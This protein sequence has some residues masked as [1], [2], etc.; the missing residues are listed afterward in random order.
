MG[1]FVLDASCIYNWVTI[2]GWVPRNL[3]IVT[4]FVT[5]FAKPSERVMQNKTNT[6]RRAAKI[7]NVF[8]PARIL[9]VFDRN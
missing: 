7:V 5:V 1:H 8:L 3:G 9:Y 6:T 2:P 4:F